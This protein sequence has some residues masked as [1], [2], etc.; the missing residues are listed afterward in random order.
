M[1]IKSWRAALAHHAYTACTR[2]RC[3]IHTL[4]RCSIHLYTRSRCS[5]HKL[6]RH[7]ALYTHAHYTH[8]HELS[9]RSAHTHRRARTHTN[10]DADTEELGWRA[11]SDSVL[12]GRAT[13]TANLSDDYG[14]NLMYMLMLVI[15]SVMAS[16]LRCRILRPVCASF[17]FS[18][19]VPCHV[20]HILPCQRALRPHCEA[21]PCT[22][23]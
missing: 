21:H 7:I 23:L 3:S 19:M 18:S 6:T 13:A 2:S 1:T 4:T 14:D 22:H 10:A 15:S 20:V 8:V 17:I 5:I 16:S 11:R 9:L 12:I